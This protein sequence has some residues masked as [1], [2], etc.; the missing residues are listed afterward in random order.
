M[1]ETACDR[2]VASPAPR[3]P[4]HLGTSLRGI[5][6]PG[7]AIADGSGEAHPER[8]IAWPNG[9]Q[10]L[11]TLSARCGLVMGVSL[12]SDRDSFVGVVFAATQTRSPGAFQDDQIVTPSDSSR[13]TES[14]QRQTNSGNLRSWQRT[15]IAITRYK[16]TANKN[17]T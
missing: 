16:F 7:P 10:F 4:Y 8:W 5:S 2:A 9:C 3:I 12:R 1:A 13:S 14:R 17:A 15:A 11:N 6:M